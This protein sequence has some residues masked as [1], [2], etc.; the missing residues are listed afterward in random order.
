MVAPPDERLWCAGC[1][2][3]EVPMLCVQCGVLIRIS[4][5]TLK[6]FIMQCRQSENVCK[7]IM[8]S[9]KPDLDYKI[10]SDACLGDYMYNNNMQPTTQEN[11]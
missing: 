6:R 9:F 1:C 2:V 4:S 10:E 3:C 11:A 5:A 8:V 7:I